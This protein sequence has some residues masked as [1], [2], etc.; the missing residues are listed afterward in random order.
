MADE[1]EIKMSKVCI[2]VSH[3]KMKI[4]E[5]LVV[6]WFKKIIH[7]LDLTKVFEYC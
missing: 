1:K 5:Y 7:S 6:L 3:L 4:P 2:R